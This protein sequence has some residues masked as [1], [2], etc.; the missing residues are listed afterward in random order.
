[1]NFNK[2]PL[3]ALKL[4]VPP[5]Q[6]SWSVFS[7][8]IFL[9]YIWSF[10]ALFFELPALFMRSSLAEVLGV[11]SYIL[12][13]ALFE[14]ITLFAVL[15]LISLVLPE[16]WSRNQWAASGSISALVITFWAILIQI[17][18]PF[19]KNWY[20]V[21]LLFFLVASNLLI[22]KF[23]KLRAAIASIT[24]RISILTNFY[25]LLSILGIFVVILR[26]L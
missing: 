26:N 9:V 19:I 3:R 1:M 13:I 15:F 22:I 10:I 2:Q 17:Q 7:A 4:H 23:P 11:A 6:A 24:T 25:L 20:V 14:S 12:A 21:P 18:G 16:K 5:F 8:C